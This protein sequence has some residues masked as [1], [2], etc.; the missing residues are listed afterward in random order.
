MKLF[1]KLKPNRHRRDIYILGKRVF[2][3]R[4][5]VNY[6]ND[7]RELNNKIDALRYDMRSY[8]M[9]AGFKQLQIDTFL[10][11][12]GK[13]P[14]EKLTKFTHKIIWSTMFNPI[15]QKKKYADKLLVR[16]YIKEK[17][18]EKYLSKVLAQWDNPS[19]IDFSNLPDSFV[20]KSSNGSGHNL[21]VR[22]KG[23]L[24]IASAINTCRYWMANNYSNVAFEMQYYEMP[25]I[26]FA[27]E[28]MDMD[29]YEYQA[30]VF[31]GKVRFIRAMTHKYDEDN[32]GTKFFDRDWNEQPFYSDL[33]KLNIDVPRPAQLDEII[34]LSEKLC[35]DFDFV[36]CDWVVL[37]NG[38][39]KFSEVTFS[40]A[41]GYNIFK[42]DEDADAVDELFGQY[43]NIPDRN[44]DGTPKK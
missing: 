34:A 3:Y 12:T 15:P 11:R 20:L 37:K 30:F 44:P 25:R 27:E 43:L 7:I 41:A 21:V 10:A 13:L 5:S 42:P 6:D 8:L 29:K 40:P 26:V 9:P 32:H 38:D 35:A 39:V 33:Y 22:D 19:E 1:Q 36:R 4:K 14:N 16:D 28:F 23:A 24:D 31:H 2:S 18:G 17:I